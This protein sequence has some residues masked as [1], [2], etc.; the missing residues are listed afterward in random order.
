[1]V[2][3][4]LLESLNSGGPV[5]NF[6]ASN[7]R[8]YGNAFQPLVD[9]RIVGL[10]W[11]RGETVPG[12][13]PTIIR[14]WDVST[15]TVLYTLGTIPDNGAIGWQATAVPEVPVVLGQREYRVSFAWQTNR[16]Y[17]FYDF[18]T[19]APP[20]WPNAPFLPVRRVTASASIGYPTNTDPNGVYGIDVRLR[21]QA[22]PI[23]WTSVGSIAFDSEIIWNTPANRYVL[24]LTT[25]PQWQT[26][27]L[28]VGVDV[29]RIPGFWMP[30]LQGSYGQQGRI[31]NTIDTFSLPG[32]Q[33]MDGVLIKAYPGTLGTLE[34]FTVDDTV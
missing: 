11:F 10:R 21:A 18:G 1:M 8:E 13:K 15:G 28:V 29:R 7:D 23:T 27:S 3:S 12:Q 16:H 32:W 31:E 20:P 25:I 6:F 5:S 26:A 34:A 14:V 33:L 4:W 22:R 24:T 17:T 19:L 2:A 9:S 30:I